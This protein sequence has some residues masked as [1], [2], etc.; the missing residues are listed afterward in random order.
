VARRLLSHFGIQKP[1]FSNFAGNEERRVAQVLETLLEG[2]SVALTTDAG[3]PGISDP[4]YILVRAC[5]EAEI[6]VVAVPGPSALSAA[7]SIC[8]LPASRV[9]FLG[10]PPRRAGERRTLLESLAHDPSTLVFYESP[11]RVRGF[12]REMRELLANRAL[13]AL[14]EITKKFETTYADP[15]P[16]DLPERGEY[17]LVAG[18]PTRGLRGGAPP[19]DAA[20]RVAEL[21]SQ[22]KSE[23]EAMKVVAR[24]SG[25]SRREIYQIVKRRE[26]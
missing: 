24:A 11:R 1:T 3:S 13:V 5:R 10:F 7:L 4:G 6:P 20:A 18:P 16:E 21:V 14:R 17:V 12:V 25:V 23:K 2:R 26:P 9:L 22:G 15:A 19:E 8:G